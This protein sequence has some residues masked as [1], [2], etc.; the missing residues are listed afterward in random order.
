MTHWILKLLK[1]DRGVSGQGRVTKTRKEEENGGSRREVEGPGKSYRG[2]GRETGGNCEVGELRDV[3]KL[4]I[5]G[6]D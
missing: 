6:R 2:N 1:V 4:E 5:W 3:I